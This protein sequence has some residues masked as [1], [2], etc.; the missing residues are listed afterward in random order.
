MYFFSAFYL[1]FLSTVSISNFYDNV[2]V[3]LQALHFVARWKSWRGKVLATKTSGKTFLGGRS[4]CP[5]VGHKKANGER[6]IIC[7]FEILKYILWKENNFRF[8]LKAGIILKVFSFY[9]TQVR[10]YSR[11]VKNSLTLLRLER[12]DSG[13]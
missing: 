8:M 1:L 10:S 6:V 11:L 7:K 4:I 5:M 2:L 13:F 3:L 12:F 9:Q